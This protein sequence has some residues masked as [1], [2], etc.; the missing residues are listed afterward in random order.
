MTYI[1]EPRFQNIVPNTKVISV[2]QR[3][4]TALYG[5][6]LQLGEVA[7]DRTGQSVNIN[8]SLW[9]YRKLHIWRQ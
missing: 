6:F 9:G 4:L 2:V 1:S 5:K 8:V 7:N 3:N